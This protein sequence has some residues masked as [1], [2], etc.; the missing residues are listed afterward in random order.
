[1]SD[2]LMFQRGEPSSSDAHLSHVY[3][4]ALPLLKRG[5]PVTP[6]QLENVTTANYLDGFRVLLLSYHGQKPLSPEVHAPLADWIRA[7]GVLVVCDDDSDPYN[8][9]REWWNSDGREF[10][11][12]REA[13]FQALGIAPEKQSTPGSA[14]AP[15]ERTRGSS[16]LQD[17][18]VEMRVDEGQVLWLREAPATLA[19]S[20][21]GDARLLG[22]VKRASELGRLN[23]RESNYLLLRRG[24]Y[25]I[26]AGLDESIA[27]APKALRGRFVNL[28]DPELV[29]RREIEVLPA[30]RWF[31][32]DL[33]QPQAKGMAILASAC[34]AQALP[35]GESAW[36]GV[37]EGVAGTP[38]VVL[39]RTTGA[40]RA[41]TL[42][43]EPL[44]DWRWDEPEQ[45]L[46]VRFNNSSSPRELTVAF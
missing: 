14:S 42:A 29:V 45:L 7:G 39:L 17:L 22:A 28:F 1:V 46:W 30:S 19:A 23:W 6:V 12:P 43:S 34:K 36:R 35:P 8:Q 33:D 10:A 40:P 9:V 18:L 41:I 44:S 4:L 5:M 24:P 37:V 2:S 31:L 32:L 16:S 25:V 13:L 20:A 15:E 11:N 27:D 38:A 26:A 3:G 21:E